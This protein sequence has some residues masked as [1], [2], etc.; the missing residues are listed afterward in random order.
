MKLPNYEFAII[1][2]GKLIDY[3]LNP[4]HLLGKHKARVFEMALGIKRQ[5]ALILKG[6]IL[7]AIAEENC[8]EAELSK[9]GRRFIVDGV[10]I[11]EM[12]EALV[13]TSW[14]IKK[15]EWLP[16]LT[17]CYVIKQE[18]DGKHF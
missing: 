13:R 18:N 10:F 15:G 17:S 2:D 3:C 11:H 7:K 14:I 16:R 9:F 12:N 4:N 1:E 5:D 8:V 6:L